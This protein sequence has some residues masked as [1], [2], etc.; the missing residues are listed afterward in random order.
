MRWQIRSCPSF[1][2]D[3]PIVAGGEVSFASSL[4]SAGTRV[5][6]RGRAMRAWIDR[7]N[8]G[9][10]GCPAHRRYRLRKQDFGTSR[11]QLSD[12]AT[13]IAGTRKGTRCRLL[14]LLGLCELSDLSAQSAQSVEM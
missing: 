1:A 10:S 6:G 5:N 13:P 8:N 12:Y 9:L 2:R 11:G 7:T 4:M 3:R 14:A